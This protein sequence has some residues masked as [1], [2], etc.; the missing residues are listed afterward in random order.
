MQFTLEELALNNGL[1]DLA[2]KSVGVQFYGNVANPQLLLSLLSKL[3][4]CYDEASKPKAEQ[5]NPPQPKR[6]SMDPQYMYT[7]EE[8]RDGLVPGIVS[9]EEPA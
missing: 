7:A 3:Q 8:I 6:A 9:N 4:I 5:P 2:L 1:I